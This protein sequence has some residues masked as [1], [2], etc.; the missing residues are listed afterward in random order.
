MFKT[1]LRAF[2]KINWEVWAPIIILVLAIIYG[3][4][5][6]VLKND[7]PYRT[8]ERAAVYSTIA[9]SAVLWVL[10]FL[11]KKFKGAKFE[12]GMIITLLLLFIVYCAYSTLAEELKLFDKTLTLHR[13]GIMMLYLLISIAYIVIDFILIRTTT[14]KSEKEEVKNSFFYCDGPTCIVFSVLLIFALISRLQKI[15]EL[16][17][18]FFS[19]AIAFQMIFA[20][21]VWYVIDNS[22]RIKNWKPI[23][24]LTGEQ[25]CQCADSTKKC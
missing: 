8:W 4:S 21:I 13:V 1:I 6:I 18:T 14:D 15:N 7:R 23:K 16:N 12:Q 9:Y 5:G 24:K 20:S 10:G 25:S 2:K 22:E 11:R 19:G 17:D 3:I